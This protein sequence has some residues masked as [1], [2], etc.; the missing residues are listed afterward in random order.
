MPIE[1]T[2]TEYE[3]VVVGA[4]YLVKNILRKL[5]FVSAI[6]EVLSH[7][8]EIEAS[9]GQLAQVIVANRLAF[10]PVPLY[11]L[12]DWAAEHGLDQVFDLDASW[13]DDD[14]VGAMLEALAKHQ[15][16]IW[17]TLV[18]NAVKRFGIELEQL[19]NDTTS[20]Y[21]EGQYEDEAGQ[22]L[23]GGER[24][25]L[26]VEGYN[27]D[28]QRNKVQFVLSVIASQRVP[29]WYRPWDGNQTDEAVYVADLHALGQAVLLPE[30]VLL[31][32]DRK[33]C[34]QATMLTF[35]RQQQRFLA[36]HPWT[37]TAKAVWERTWHRLQN[38]ELQWTPV[39]YVSRNNARKPPHQRPQYRACEVAYTLNDAQTPAGHRLRWVFVWSSDK[40][41]RDARQRAKALQAGQAA[42]QRIKRLLG[43]YDYTRRQTIET[44]L[45]K[46][47][48]QAKASPYF[49]ASLAGTDEDQAWHLQ[50]QQHQ[51]VITERQRFDGIVLMCTN[52]PSQDLS[53]VEVMTKYKEQVCI[54]QTIDFI[55]SPVQIRPLW[56]H[57]PRRLSGL[58][59]LI[60]IA[61]LVAALLEHQVRR[62]IAKTGR[63]IRG[64]RPEG[65]DDPYPTAKAMLKAFQSYAIVLVRH[66]QGRQEIHHPKLRP[67]QQQ[68][69]NILELDPLPP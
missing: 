6:D 23:G 26:L 38:D 29:L 1:T 18:N 4:A 46:A 41:A 36:P 40:A 48:Q 45:A 50:W 60:M 28:G 49:T 37:E 13:L 54:E 69:W 10:Q 9:Y 59:L 34:N 65:R 68:L 52:A 15:V 24:V 27:K 66:G 22:P 47:L 44:R 20:V 12:A 55:K 53:T 16:S 8:P 51:A 21:F 43:K 33:L 19:H 57:S 11:G 63:L 58:T 67:V 62:R 17:S 32:G 30:N 64:L 35:C 25:P 5:G 61:V 42:L 14:R 31:I 2:T 3:T 7:Q 39:A 56:L